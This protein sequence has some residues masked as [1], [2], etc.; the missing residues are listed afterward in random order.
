MSHHITSCVLC[1]YIIGDDEHQDALWMNLFRILYSSEEQVAV[2]GVGFLYD[3]DVFTWVAPLDFGARWD[4]SESRVDIGVGRQHP[5]NGRHGFPFHE[6]CWSLL[7]KVYSPRPI[8]QK[9]LFEVCRSLPFSDQLNCLT[10]GH[11]YEGLISA[12]NDQYPYVDLF[13][14][15][16]LGRAR[17]D[18]YLVPEIQ[19]LP[20]EAPT[21]P[22]I[23][24]KLVS[25]SA[26]IFAKLPLEIITS[27]SLHLPTAD[28][29]NTRLVSPSFHPVFHIQR[30]W[31]SRFL[32]N[33][34]RSW[35]FESQ[36][37]EKI[38]D[39]RWLYHRTAD[40]TYGMKNRKR[41]WQLA[42]KVKEILSSEWTEPMSYS[43]ADATEVNWL[44]ASANTLT[45]ARLPRH[46]FIGGCRQFHHR[47]VSIPPDQLSHLAFSL[48]RPGD[49]TYITGIRLVLA[50]GEIIQ[51][52]Y[53]AEEERVLNIA[54][55]TGFNL[56]I[57]PRGIQGIQ[58]ISDNDGESP[59]VG[60]PDDVP[61]TERLRFVGPITGIKASFDGYKMVRLGATGRIRP[62][63]ETLRGS[64]VWYPR[65]PKTG[66][67]L[68]ESDY[69]AREVAMTNFQPIS[70]T[71]FGGPAGRYLPLLTGMS[72]TVE[73]GY[74]TAIEFH[75]NT[76]VVPPECRK[77][78][79]CTPSVD[80]KTIDFEID[81]PGG[82]VIDSLTLHTCHFLPE[83][84]WFYKFGV[85]ES[86]E[87][88]PLHSTHALSNKI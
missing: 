63:Q 47:H 85:V 48:I 70:W 2:T 84:R 26:D 53:M 87:E 39:W 76:W 74:P 56:A 8:P 27:I 3:A 31:A 66:L 73:I 51:L 67:Y 75:Y 65:I 10:W 71:L 54:C 18:P 50:R 45:D 4:T 1:G 23:S 38:C 57:G 72:V 6:A 19:Q 83:T 55:L 81:G 60:C 17:N 61:R 30:F 44:E 68:N 82:E 24:T 86:F 20:Y 46:G 21:Q 43:I 33:A 80:A 79:R 32:P 9:Q 42:E 69:T 11:D 78:G 62:G 52:G 49:G 28:Y 40:G 16:G 77:L 58:C 29:L 15:Q 35:V 7:E 36:N 25:K 5:A 14:D 22:D 88:S 12:N 64:A 34:D 13:V 41:V 59:W 37:W